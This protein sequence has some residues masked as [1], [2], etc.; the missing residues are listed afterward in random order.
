MV[1]VCRMRSCRFSLSQGSRSLS[2]FP[3]GAFFA[4]GAARPKRALT[5]AVYG[6]AR[7]FFT[8]YIQTLLSEDILIRL[9]YDC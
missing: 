2:R 9:G 5:L 3:C 4:L 6:T 1:L 8:V 7:Q